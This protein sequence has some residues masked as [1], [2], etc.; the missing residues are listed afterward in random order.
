M[1]EKKKKTPER[2]IP[3]RKLPKLSDKTR[4]IDGVLLA[5]Q[6]QERI[7]QKMRTMGLLSRLEKFALGEGDEMTPA[8]VSAALGLLKKSLPDMQ[9]VEQKTEVSVKKISAE[10]LMS[11]DAWELQYNP[12]DAKGNDVKPASKH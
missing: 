10:P 11:Q 7:R 12:E 6:A 1:S 3:R 9:S 4:G 8:Q 2:R 5:P